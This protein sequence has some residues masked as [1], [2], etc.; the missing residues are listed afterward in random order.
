M[1]KA[2]IGNGGHAREI[3]AQMNQRLIRFVD[4]KYWIEGDDKLLPLSDFN[5][6][7]YEVMIAVGS[8]DDR[9]NI[10]KKLPKETKY[11]SFIH[12]TVLILDDSIQ[13]G[14]GTF[15]G[16]YSVLTTN[17]KVGKHSLLNRSNHI[18]HDCQIGDY[19]TLMP[20]AIVSGDCNISDNVYV[21]TNSSIREKISICDDVIIGLNSGV[22]SDIVESGVYVGTPAKKIK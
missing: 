3:M 17:I 10:S 21:G 19:L 7:I 13:I 16:A 9:L 6:E 8:S 18:G 22:V 15:I 1:I 11:F 20:G 2:L 14:D 4:D 5:P 12:N